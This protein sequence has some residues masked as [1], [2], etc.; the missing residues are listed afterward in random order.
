MS[1]SSQGHHLGLFPGVAAGGE[2][3]GGDGTRP[4]EM[5]PLCRVSL[6]ES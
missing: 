2:E 1:G 4:W 3:W 6:G 5:V